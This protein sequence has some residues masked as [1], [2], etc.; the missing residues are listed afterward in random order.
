MLMRN[1]YI[2]LLIL[3]LLVSKCWAFEPKPTLMILGFENNASK[4]LINS[5]DIND[6][7]LINELTLFQLMQ[8]DKYNIIDVENYDKLV[9]FRQQLLTGNQ[10]I[11]ASQSRPDCDLVL[12]GN[13]N[14]LSSSF[15]GLNVNKTIALAADKN[16]VTCN[17][18]ARIVDAKTGNILLTG[19]GF[20]KSS[21][22]YL[23]IEP[24][25]PVYERVKQRTENYKICVG[26]QEI[27]AGMVYNAI[28]KA[29][30]DMFTNKQTG[31][32]ARWQM[33]QGS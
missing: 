18:S 9:S 3:C 10:G 19:R 25:N 17:V 22:V 1:I 32:G 14:N 30:A 7:R 28:N 33:K 16:N 23:T 27:H 4:R 29:V 6:L 21:S 26:T 2:L 8:F 13:I 31:F 5:L 12:V 20:G 11:V 15:S 24:Y